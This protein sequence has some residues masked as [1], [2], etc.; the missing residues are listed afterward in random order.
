MADAFERLSTAL[1]DRY[2][3]ERELGQGGMATVYLAADLKHQRKVAIKV[4]RPELAAVLGAERFVQEITT[5]AQLQHPHILPL[6]DS[7]SADGFLFYVMPY[8]EGE[9][10]RDKLNRETQLGVD[11]AVKI[12]T[13]AA[14]ALD[15]A[16]RHG[17]IH[18]DIK[19]E[20]I[21]LHD[22]RP[23]VADFGIA[24]ALSAAAGGR[25][26]ETGLSLGTPHYMSPEQA[27]AD[28][29]ITARS[30]VYSLASVLYEML[31]GDPPHTGS[32][33]QQIIMKIVTEQA[34]PVT[35]LRKSVPPNVAA[36]VAQALEKVPADRFDSAKSL[37]EAL[38]NPHFV[39][40][41]G[42]V[43][44]AGPPVRRSAAFVVLAVMT[45]AA[46]AL[47]TWGW[48]RGA[49]PPP[50]VAQFDIRVTGSS[51][52]ASFDNGASLAIAPDGSRFVYVAS[53]S[54]LYARDFGQL[55][56]KALPARGFAPFF[57]PDGKWVGYADGTA[58]KKVALTGDPPLTITLVAPDLS[59]G[60]SWGEDGTIVFAPYVLSPLFLV[61]D[62]GGP[63]DTLTHL[64]AARG[65]ASHRW[66]EWLPGQHG[67]LFE[68]CG[69]AADSCEIAVF[70]RRTDSVRYLTPGLSPHYVATGHLVY[71]SP[72]GA[73]LAAP[74]DLD[75][76]EMTGK[77]VSLMEGILVRASWNGDFGIAGNGT[78]LYLSGQTTGYDLTLLDSAGSARVLL[79]DLI[80]AQAPALS[81][82]GR[83]VAFAAAREGPYEIWIFDRTQESV[84]RLTFEGNA[85]YPAWNPSGDTVYYSTEAGSRDRDI[86]RRAADGS[87]DP[88]RVLERPEDQMSITIPV[89]GGAALLRE[90]VVS[91]PG[92]EGGLYALPLAPVGEPRPWVVS[93]FFE[94]GP[95]FSPDARWAAYTSNESGQDEIYVRAFPEPKGRWQVSSGGGAE[96]LWSVD[97]RTIYY[98]RADTLFAAA[99]KASPTFSVGRQRMVFAAGF[100][101][102]PFHG[103]TN[104]DR[105]PRTGEFVVFSQHEGSTAALVVVLN[106]FEELRRRAEA[107]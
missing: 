51:G 103:V 49:P 40:T 21:L 34:A 39:G 78:L 53:D 50:A 71:T 97:G 45:L 55:R 42:S 101:P 27:T 70:D 19:P 58:L 93:S 56:S 52:P 100:N 77:P 94:R 3:I 64:D 85:M 106:W 83:R 2:Q 23:M 104:Y 68:A 24:L 99:V 63:V 96:P 75:R 9:T 17:V 86:W 29:D 22:G 4:L 65:V 26:T 20:N 30:D 16:H 37:A 43:P 12:T 28:K 36:A 13:E 87:G 74:F 79:P 59:R 61:P 1:A 67:V 66:P 90:N 33:A 72:T 60:A 73:L 38:A 8:I 18:R 84:S 6:F 88:E 107:M 47:A 95:S 7:G 31:T 89:A 46:L 14:D 41:V 57:S 82:D 32:S 35:K 81:P 98:R 25:M 80:D 92:N 76:M 102:S 10:L 69:G 54:G 48:F 91:K 105:D 5:T 44:T 11:E 62:G 15:Y